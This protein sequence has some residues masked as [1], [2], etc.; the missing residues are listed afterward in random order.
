VNTLRSTSSWFECW[1]PGQL[2]SGG[3][4]TWYWTL[5]DD[6]GSRGFAPA[7]ALD[8][9]SAF[10]ANPTAHGLAKCGD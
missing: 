3:N 7:S 6:N 4:T 2:H 8:T 5:G 10:D 1:F 9:S